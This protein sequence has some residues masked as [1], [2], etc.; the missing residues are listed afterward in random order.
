MP[1]ARKQIFRKIILSIYCKIG[2]A[3][4]LFNKLLTPGQS[5]IFASI[6]PRE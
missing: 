6:E 2:F 5:R 4:I 3:K 1:M